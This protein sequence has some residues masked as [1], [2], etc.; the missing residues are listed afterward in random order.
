MTLNDYLQTKL[1]EPSTA[2][3]WGQ[4]FIEAFN[5]NKRGFY[6]SYVLGLEATKPRSKAL[7]GTALHA[8]V[9]SL[10]VARDPNMDPSAQMKLVVTTLLDE[11]L[12]G[13]DN[14]ERATLIEAATT[15]ALDWC[16]EIWLNDQDTV[17]VIESERLL[18]VKLPNGF[19]FTCRL[20]RTVRVKQTGRKRIRE[21]KTTG[22]RLD[23]YI[24]RV[25]DGD[26]ITAYLWAETTFAPDDPPEGAEAE[27][28]YSYRN[29]H[30][31]AKSELI[32]RS[33]FELDDYAD[34]LVGLYADLAGRLRL[35]PRVDP[36][37]ISLVWPGMYDETSTFEDEFVSLRRLHPKDLED[38]S[39][40]SMY[41]FRIN[42]QRRANT[43]AFLTEW[44]KYDDGILG[45][46]ASTGLDNTGHL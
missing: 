2:S 33:R 42:E 26:Q 41:G 43:K 15:M 28:T 3:Q 4:S 29:S 45:Y 17:E 25:T 24:R 31:C 40:T 16:S 1:A 22:W 44:S 37:H 21:L 7:R 18:A 13:I 9:E 35:W 10:Y 23:E 46:M 27:V 39:I 36:T 32:T 20:D 38:P 19:P 34:K 5:K 14:E 12:A 30:K 6:L 8:A 11:W